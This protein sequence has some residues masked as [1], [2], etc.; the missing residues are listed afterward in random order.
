MAGTI[1]YIYL[2]S[3]NVAAEFTELQMAHGP[4]PIGGPLAFLHHFI[5]AIDGGACL[6]LATGS[7]R[8][9][10]VQAGNITI[11]AAGRGGAIR[12]M[13]RSIYYILQARP[14]IILCGEKGLP[15]A[16]S[17]V[18]GAILNAKVVFS[19]HNTILA[20]N[21]TLRQ[22]ILEKINRACVRQAHA[23]VCHGPFLRAELECL[24]EPVGLFEYDTGGVDLPECEESFMYQSSTKIILFIGRL[25]KE[26]GVLDLLDAAEPMLV[27]DETI[28]LIYVGGGSGEEALRKNIRFRGL[29]GQVELV[30]GIPHYEISKFI[31]KAYVVVTPTRS[32]F[33]EGRC[34]AAMESMYLGVPVIAPDFG[35]FPYLVK[36]EINGLLYKPD[37]VEMLRT[38]LI[39]ILEDP[40]LRQLFSRSAKNS[41][42][43]L[44]GKDD[45]ATAL[46][47]S[48]AFITTGH[49]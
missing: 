38:Q 2:K 14:L 37:S 31:C 3:G 18:C 27:K 11:V 28:Q 8:H 33:P 32:S 22:R 6:L 30:G 13:L 17:V 39:R 29:E 7:S 48:F 35:P 43:A 34:M 41:M 21:N 36:N 25:E 23:C 10:P 9:E 4:V 26:K 45:F 5:A 12:R 47:K 15:F 20:V 19:S 42:Q 49:E 40:M 1:P 24:R 44:Q 46:R 16:V